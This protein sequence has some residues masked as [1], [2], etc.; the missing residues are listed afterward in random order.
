MLQVTKFS[1]QLGTGS[2]G[3]SESFLSRR[4]AVS[5][6]SSICSFVS[7]K[8]GF[9]QRGVSC[10]TRFLF[11]S[12]SFSLT[13]SAESI[14]RGDI[15]VVSSISESPSSTSNSTVSVN[16][17]SSSDPFFSSTASDLS[18]WTTEGTV[19]S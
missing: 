14:R 10:F 1:C 6:A 17:L 19:F 15:S 18:F 7:S 3:G 2:L 5:F 8:N 13:F 12:V 16:F 11:S 9:I 4:L